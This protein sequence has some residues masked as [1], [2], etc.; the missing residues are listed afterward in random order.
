MDLHSSLLWCYSQCKISVNTEEKALHLV[1]TTCP[2]YWLMWPSIY[3]TSSTESGRKCWMISTIVSTR[4]RYFLS[5]QRLKNWIV[6]TN[7]CLTYQSFYMANFLSSSSCDIGP[8][9]STPLPRPVW[10]PHFP[11]LYKA[12]RRLP[13]QPRAL[14]HQRWGGRHD[15]AGFRKS[16]LGRGYRK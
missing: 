6:Q 13:W 12:A 16:P 8:K 2:D 5:V 7:L 10:R 3:A 1:Q 14:P 11:S 9:H 4:G 15:R